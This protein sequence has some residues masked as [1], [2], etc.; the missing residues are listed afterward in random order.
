[1]SSHLS[2]V[3]WDHFLSVNLTPDAICTNFKQIFFSAADLFV[4]QRHSNG[5]CGRTAIALRKYPS[6][7]RKHFNKK[8]L[9]WRACRA[10]PNNIHLKN[11]FRQIQIEC[12]QL[13]RK[14][15]LEHEQR[16]I[17][18]GSSGGFYLY[19]NSKLSCSS[20]V[21]SLLD[22]NGLPLTHDISKAN[23]M[24]LMNTLHQCA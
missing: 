2:L 11:R 10:Q 6:K 14:Y 1:M 7:I 9:L 4:P 24:L 22:P 21:G 16:I 19:V 12:R 8:K 13:L 5:T 23:A 20:G 17:D 3:D 18:S 15:E